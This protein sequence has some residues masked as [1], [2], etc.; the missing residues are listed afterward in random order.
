[1]FGFIWPVSTWTRCLKGSNDEPNG[2]PNYLCKKII[3]GSIN[4]NII[5]HSSSLSDLEF[6]RDDKKK[7]R[8]N[9]QLTRVQNNY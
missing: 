6:D 3:G 7:F 2:P 9:D 1:M 5:D 4:T 8:G